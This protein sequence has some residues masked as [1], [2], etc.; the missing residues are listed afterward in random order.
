[1]NR[2]YSEPNRGPA[3]HT[4]HEEIAKRYSRKRQKLSKVERALE[5][6]RTQLA[7][8]FVHRGGLHDDDDGRAKVR[9]LLEL[10]MIGPDV[11]DLA[12]WMSGKELQ[13]I[14][15]DVD[16]RPPRGWTAG[17]IGSRWEITLEEKIDCE[18]HQIDCCDADDHVVAAV[19]EDRRRQRNA[20]RMSRKRAEEGNMTRAEYLAKSTSKARPWEALGIKRRAW[21][22]RRRKGCVDPI[23]PTQPPISPIA[24][25]CAHPSLIN[26]HTP[27]QSTGHR[28]SQSAP[29]KRTYR[30]R[31]SGGAN[32][33]PSP[34][35]VSLPASPVVMTRSKSGRRVIWYLDHLAV[36]TML[37]DTT[38]H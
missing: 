34:L 6:R 27:V 8:L 29:S 1:M 31:P 14:I 17:Q 11:L 18:M 3:T 20:E 26:A 9:M 22:Y 30:E 36:A 21:Y 28:A 19:Y 12:P 10:A 2:D 25:V 38:V 4:N 15:D 16:S 23:A 32:P 13:S 33:K 37:G 7:R 5:R 24:Q 35:P